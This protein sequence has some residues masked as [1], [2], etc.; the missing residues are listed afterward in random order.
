MDSVEYRPLQNEDIDALGAI[1]GDIWD[2]YT[3]V[4]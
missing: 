1:L 3:E 4:R 2:S